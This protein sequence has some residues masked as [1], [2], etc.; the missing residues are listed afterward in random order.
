MTLIAQQSPDLRV[1]GVSQYF[2]RRGGDT[3]Q[4]LDD[5]SLSIE[6]GTFVSLVGA[7]GCGKST[8]LKIMAGLVQPTTGTVTLGGEVLDAP[9]AERGMVFQQDA[10]FPWLSVLDNIAY[11][12]RGRGVSRAE[13][14]AAALRW[15]ALV[16][17]TGFEDA[18]PKELSGGMRKRVDIARVYANEP[19]ILMMD[20]PFGALDAQ[21]KERM[22]REL[23]ELW[24]QDRRTVVFVTHDLD[25]AVYLSDQIVVMSA[26][27]GRIKEIVDVD[28]P[29]PRSDELRMS[30]PFQETKRRL[31]QLIDH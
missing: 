30:Q 15:A 28:L 27:P 3:M 29:R 2:R 23:L 25:E 20:E 4:A 13:S 26:R 21:T 24:E 8:L 22:Q 5:I 31:Y 9:G 14:R 11:G 10:V 6:P 18:M 19:E 16:G 12:P 17:L 1:N 7:S